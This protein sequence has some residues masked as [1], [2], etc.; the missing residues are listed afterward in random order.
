MKSLILG[1]LLCSA[2]EAKEF[3]FT[4]KLDGSKIEYKVEAST[5]EEA[6]VQGAQFCF[7]FF[8]KDQKKI[9]EERGLD[10]IDACA[11]PK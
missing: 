5:W 8:T 9:S 6:F 1:L 2:A 7:G 3:S 10:I 11:N 4:Y